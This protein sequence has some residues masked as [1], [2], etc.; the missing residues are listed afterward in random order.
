[1]KNIDL[2]TVYD[3]GL[4]WKS[5]DQSTLLDAEA[6]SIFLSYFKIFPQHFLNDQN[7][8]MDIGCG[9]GRWAKIVAPKVKKLYCLDASHDAIQ[10]A[11]KNLAGRDNIDY[12]N[13]SLD[14]M[15]VD[16]DILDFAYSLGVLHHVPNPLLGIKSCVKKLK[17]GA[18]LLIYVYYALDNKPNWFRVIWKLSNHARKFISKLPFRLKWMCSQMIAFFIYYP[19]AKT[20][21]IMEKLNIDVSHFPL[22]AY[23]KLGFYTMRTDALDRFGTQLEHRFTKD[24]IVLMLKESGLEKIEVS[25]DAPYWCAIGYKK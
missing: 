12:I 3:F 16:D 25:P 19:F 7:T 11:K 5:F 8:G 22:S 20:A 1:M 9:S 24:E 10:V 15:P 23:R 6:E 17:S 14:E 4:E 13:A 2:K 18:P 21:L